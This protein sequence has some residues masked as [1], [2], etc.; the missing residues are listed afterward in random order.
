MS[1]FDLL[2]QRLPLLSMKEVVIFPRNIITL[3]IG[4]PRSVLAIEEALATDQKLIFTMQRTGSEEGTA[5]AFHRVGTLVEIVNFERRET[6]GIQI[7]VE[8]MARVRLSQIDT[9][10]NVITAGA[11]R[12]AEVTPDPVEADSMLRLI[13]DLTL[14]Y[15]DEKGVPSSEVIDMVRRASDPGQLADLLATQLLAGT[16]EGKSLERQALLEQV[17]PLQRLQTLA[18]RI[19][20]EIDGAA[21]LRRANEQIRDRAEAEHH[22][23]AIKRQ[24]DE[25]QKMLDPEEGDEFDQFRRRILNQ[26]LPQQVED[27]LLN[28]LRRLQG[29][30]PVSAEATVVRTYLDTLLSLPWSDE[31]ID[32]IDLARAEEIL[33]GH[34][35]GLES[36]KERVLDYLAVRALGAMT[37]RTGSSPILCLV[38]PPGVG[39]RVSANRLP[40]RWSGSSRSSASAAF[41]TKLKSAV[42]ARRTSAPCRAGLSRRSISRKSRTRSSCSTRSTSSPATNGAIRPRRCSKCS[43]RVKNQA[44]LDHYLEV[45]Y[46]LS[47]VLF[48]ATANY[49]QQI[50]QPLADRMELIDLAGYY[51]DEK[52]EISRRHLLPRQIHANSLG[53]GDLLVEDEVLRQIVRSYTREAGVRGLEREIATI[54]RKAASLVFKEGDAPPIEISLRRLEEDLGPPRFSIG[55]SLGGSEVGVATGLGTTE[56]GG[57]LIQ[58]EVVT[59]PG[60]GDL[61]ITGNAGD[62]MRESALAALT[63]ARTRSA[64]FGIDPDFQ[65]KTDIHIHLPQGAMPKDGPSAGITMATALISSLTNRPIRNDTAMTGEITLRGHVLAIGGLRDKALAAHRSGIRRL[66]APK[67]NDREYDVLP[68]RVR[69]EIDFFFVQTMDEVIE[70]SFLNV[71]SDDHPVDSDQLVS[72]R[73]A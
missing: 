29:M 66:I 36:V 63:Y 60:R 8:G 10:G 56:V 13:K 49:K 71:E 51:E 62:V 1:R 38:G 18:I 20:G 41:A 40:K 52:V 15:R 12:L 59:M 28:E 53:D 67:V 34:H 72:T 25:L 47:K 24:I 11:E 4:K 48:I 30:Q 70:C 50:P 5:D 3:F 57:E 43:I 44:F 27:R 23:A 65:E 39:K 9:A 14:R 54:C 45:P 64:M 55:E 19:R 37:G 58:V 32:R 26:G 33:N 16:D 68:A 69:D 2:G 31:T 35:Y 61:R 21:A 17:D 42:T 46:D 73:L 6:S 7:V 22:R